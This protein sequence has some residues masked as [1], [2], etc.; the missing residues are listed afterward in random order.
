MRQY[1][2]ILFY[3]FVIFAMFFGSGNLVLP[4][5]IGFLSG[6]HWIIG[7]LGLFLAGV[8]LPFLGLLVIKLHK[9][10]YSRFFGEAGFIAKICL[11]FFIVS[12]MGPF[13]VAP[14]CIVVAHGGV[15]YLLPNISLL[16]FSIFFSCI[17]FALCLKDK[18]M[19]KIL[20]KYLSPIKL[21]T[22]IALIAV[23]VI[24]APT[25]LQEASASQTLMS[26]IF[27][28]YQTMDLFAAFF[29]SAMLFKQIQDFL[30]KGTSDSDILKF[31]IK[32][33]V[34][35]FALLA[36][37]YLGL[38]FLSSHYAF[39][40]HDM[41]PKTML[42]AIA[43]HTMGGGAAIFIACAMFF[44]CLATAVALNNIYA[45]YMCDLLN[46]AEERFPIVLLLTI[47]TSFAMSLLDFG[48]IAAFLVPILEVS[49]PGLIA[50]TIMSICYRK[51]HRIKMYVFWIITVLMTLKFVDVNY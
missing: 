39:L 12:L 33:G 21:T 31:S 15:Q 14:R 32:A 36:L 30:P 37:I 7:F 40:L 50:L 43:M 46:L 10:D 47:I 1:K 16:S 18:I 29:F 11:P 45:R 26:G 6:E 19:V 4:L 25:A 23:G 42:S 49:Y 28:A 2:S 13:G 8:I 20:G 34:V 24:N 22:L 3:G 48:G 35:G 44:S 51:E 41:S 27:I 9:G 38:I 5:Q 17:T